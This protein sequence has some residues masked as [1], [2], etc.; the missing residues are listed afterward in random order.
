[1]S[2]SGMLREQM[3]KARK[4]ARAQSGNARTAGP[5]GNLDTTLELVGSNKWGGMVL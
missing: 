5:N 3:M 2:A 1:M 4:A